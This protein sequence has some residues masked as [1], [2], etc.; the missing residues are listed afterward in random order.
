MAISC[1]EAI[2]LFLLWKIP[3]TTVT[4]IL[5][6]VKRLVAVRPELSLLFPERL[7]MDLCSLAQICLQYVYTKDL[8]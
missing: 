7:D 6:I 2:N 8:W 1:R 3:K 4:A 5:W